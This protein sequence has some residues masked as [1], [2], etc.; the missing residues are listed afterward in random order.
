M[1]LMAVSGWVNHGEHK[2]GL[3]TKDTNDTKKEGSPRPPWSV[4][5]LLS[6]LF[7]YEE[8]TEN[9]KTGLNHGTQRTQR[10]KFLR[11]LPG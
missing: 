5:F 7:W 9:T 2:D 10:K 6:G 8:T 1:T 4:F 3:K 11:V